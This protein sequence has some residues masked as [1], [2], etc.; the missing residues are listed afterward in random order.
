MLA[1]L[2]TIK[3]PDQKSVVRNNSKYAIH[4]FIYFPMPIIVKSSSS[5]SFCSLIPFSE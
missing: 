4:Y 2:P 1:A 5:I 3:F